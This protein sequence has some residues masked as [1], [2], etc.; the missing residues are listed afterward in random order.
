MVALS[1][2]KKRSALLLITA[3]KQ[4]SFKIL[5]HHL[6]KKLFICQRLFIFILTV[7]LQFHNFQVLFQTEYFFLG[8]KKT[9]KPN[10]RN[11]KKI[12]AKK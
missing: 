6:K 8:D 10:L 11:S 2:F 7:S 5:M 1:A 9:S 12:S 4:Y 3:K